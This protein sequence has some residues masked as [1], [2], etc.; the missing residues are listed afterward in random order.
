MAMAA[1]ALTA[2]RASCPVAPV[3]ATARRAIG[4][5]A[6]HRAAVEAGFAL[7]PAL[8]ALALA[9][10]AD[11]IEE[12]LTLAERGARERGAFALGWADG[13]GVR[14]ILALRGGRLEAALEHARAAVELTG[15]GAYTV[16][17][18]QSLVLLAAALRERGE[19]RAAERALAEVPTAGVSTTWAVEARNEAAAIAL[20]RGEHAK[21]VREA[22]AAGELI[23]GSGDLLSS[24]RA[25]AALAL[26]AAGEGEQAA[27][28]AAERLEDAR[29]F[30]A[31]GA[32]GSALRVQGLVLD[33]AD[34]LVEAERALSGS[35]ARLEHARALVDLGAALRR[36]ARAQ[37]REPLSAGL[38][39]AYRCGAEPLVERALTELRA[40]GAR[41]RRVVRT[42][43]AALTPSE[44][45]IAE[46]A[47]AGR[48]NR[49][50]AGELYVT[51]AT[52]ETHLRSVFR[53]LDVRSR[54]ELGDR[55]A[56]EKPVA[57]V[58]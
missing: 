42:G 57:R 53:K 49:E 38:D 1:L 46:L 47:A 7:F 27:R 10:E 33:D 20:A 32:V 41:P 22:L 54:D 11:G 55:L 37:S 40:A 17:R 30:G 13:L 51:K 36:G 9:D 5:L 21:A 31:P 2:C 16:P 52:V 4:D 8:V 29:A 50:I 39:A 15:D 19:L 58:D 44:R 12:R 25:I 6:D 18:A 14:A 43:L 28:L 34:L 23:D 3:V 45:R 24:W 35:L 48:S 56:G 26:R